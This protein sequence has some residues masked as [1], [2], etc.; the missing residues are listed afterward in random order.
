MHIQELQQKL[1]D[2]FQSKGLNT[3]SSVAYKLGLVQST[4]HRALYGKPKRMTKTLNILCKYAEID[5]NDKNIDPNDSAVLMDAIRYIW[6]GSEEHA[7]RIARLLKLVNS[8]NIK[9]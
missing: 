4:V 8:F 5:L 1:I 7:K 6:D 2:S 9:P 3:T